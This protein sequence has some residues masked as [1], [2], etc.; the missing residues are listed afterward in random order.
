VMCPTGAELQRQRDKFHKAAMAALE[1]LKRSSSANA[2]REALEKSLLAGRAY[3]D[4]IV[5]VEL[6]KEC[7]IRLAPR[8]YP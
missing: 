1:V 3:E 4:L 7:C 2:K 6:C 5:H 8:S